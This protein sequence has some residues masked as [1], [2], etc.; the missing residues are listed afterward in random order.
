VSYVEAYWRLCAQY[1]A[2]ADRRLYTQRYEVPDRASISKYYGH[3]YR[4]LYRQC[5]GSLGG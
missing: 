5:Y 1:H 4:R 3:A 2:E